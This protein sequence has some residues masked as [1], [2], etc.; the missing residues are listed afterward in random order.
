V[1]DFASTAKALHGLL[2]FPNT[3]PSAAVLPLQNGHIGVPS[4]LKRQPTL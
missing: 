2:V 3:R 1:H 4:D